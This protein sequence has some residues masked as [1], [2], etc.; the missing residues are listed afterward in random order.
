MCKSLKLI[1]GEK[2]INAK[3]KG[4]ALIEKGHDDLIK[5]KFVS[6]IMNDILELGD[7]ISYIITL[8]KEN[9]LLDLLFNKYFNLFFLSG[10][11][12]LGP[13]FY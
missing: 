11:S 5:N 4:W 13:D 12:A 1:I 8:Y 6:K 2:S 10:T 7:Y 9:S 3:N